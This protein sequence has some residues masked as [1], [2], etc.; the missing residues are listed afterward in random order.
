MTL[1][2][3]DLLGEKW[4]DGNVP[5]TGYLRGLA[6]LVQCWLDCSSVALWRV[7]RP[8]SCR[9][10][11]CLSDPLSD[12]TPTAAST[13]VGWLSGFAPAD[14]RSVLLCIHSKVTHENEEDGAFAVWSDRP[15]AFLETLVS[16]NGRPQ[17]IL[18]CYQESPRRWS[19]EDIAKLRQIGARV[20]LHIARLKR[21]PPALSAFSNSMRL[22]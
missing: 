3:L 19:I 4:V 5:Y 13:D 8:L 16:V 18:S 21:K 10:F 1:S 22:T 17:A 7:D 11:C 14:Q 6:E 9:A 20:A 2:Q 12:E 15:Q